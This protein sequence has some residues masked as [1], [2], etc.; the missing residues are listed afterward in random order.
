MVAFQLLQEILDDVASMLQIN[1]FDDTIQK[2]ELF[3]EM[4][5]SMCKISTHH[6]LSDLNLMT[7]HSLLIHSHDYYHDHDG[8][9]QV[10]NIF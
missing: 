3:V 6:G 5:T 10:N 8:Y 2:F 9:L 4:E 1:H 7:T